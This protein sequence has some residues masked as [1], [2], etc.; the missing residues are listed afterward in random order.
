MAKIS[1]RDLI[2]R[3]RPRGG[4]P[5]DGKAFGEIVRLH[6]KRVYSLAVHMLRD[7]T[8]AEDA[9]QETF[10]RAYRA[11]G[12]F[13]GKSQLYTWIHRIAIHVCL[14]RLRSG[15]AMSRPLLAGAKDAATDAR[16]EAL[17]PT[18][19]ARDA[20]D[21]EAIASRREVYRA[22]ASGVDTLSETL[23]TTLILV[24]IEG[25]SHDEV[26][27][28]LGAPTGTIAWRVHEA[29]RKLSEYMTAKGFRGEP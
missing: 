4:T 6:Q 11:L 20:A 12:Q 21:G 26:A 18:D 23:R 2:E 14:N 28:I 25:F 13:E 19:E 10:L 7:R 17:P 22:L 9:V 27:E 5:G 29:R 8:E 16:L 15:R 3:S 1:D 24:C